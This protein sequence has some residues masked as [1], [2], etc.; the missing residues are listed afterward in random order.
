MDQTI[1]KVYDN[2]YTT[3]R[4]SVGMTDGGGP[5]GFD[6]HFAL[7][8]D[9]LVNAYKCDAIFETGTNGGDT[10]EYL[11]KMYS[12]KTIITSEINKNIFDLAKNRLS[13]RNNIIL[14]NESSE[15]VLE[16]YKDNFTMPFYYL[17]A[18]WYDYWPLRDELNC[19]NHGIVC[20]SDFILGENKDGI[21]YSGDSYKG[22]AL[23]HQFLLEAGVTDTIYVNNHNGLHNYPLPCLQQTR[24]TG[25]AYFCKNV[26][27]TFF[28]S[29]PNLFVELS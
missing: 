6:I 15:I 8:V 5:F 11:S 3:P 19:I 7:E 1:Q 10:T 25:R 24:R 28:K 2:F 9:Y 20:V 12:E 26:E 29:N 22:V 4:F 21:Y 17:D 18:H 14:N 13:D 23:N 27:D 16:R